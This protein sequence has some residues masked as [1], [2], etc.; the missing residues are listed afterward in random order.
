[1]RCAGLPQYILA[2]GLAYQW[3]DITTVPGAQIFVGINCTVLDLTANPFP[4]E[5]AT[6]TS[7]SV[8]AQGFLSFPDVS[9]AVCVSNAITNDGGKLEK[10]CPWPLSASNF[11]NS[12]ISFF[13]G[14]VFA[15]SNFGS[16]QYAAWFDACPYIALNNS[17][18]YVIEILNLQWDNFNPTTA[19][20]VEIILAENGDILIQ[21]NGQ[22]TSYWGGAIFGQQ[23]V[24]AVFSCLYNLPRWR[25]QP[26]FVFDGQLLYFGCWTDSRWNLYRFSPSRKSCA[27]STWLSHHH[28]HWLHLS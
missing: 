3:I 8:N 20:S 7:V 11:G 6:F 9:P 5:G 12:F 23:R 17:W 15:P 1:M 16:T 19:V 22:S 13:M 4:F 27:L 26:A 24:A 10:L 25:S 18:C 28:F 2:D 21:Y 14:N